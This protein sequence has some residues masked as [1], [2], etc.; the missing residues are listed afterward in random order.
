MVELFEEEVYGE[1]LVIVGS[2]GSWEM[3]ASEMGRVM[4]GM[5]RVKKIYLRCIGL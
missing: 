1:E 4:K 3:E 2:L 5:Q